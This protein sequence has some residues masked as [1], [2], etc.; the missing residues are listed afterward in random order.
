VSRAD[1]SSLGVQLLVHAAGGMA[2]LLVPAVLSVYKPSGLT[3][4]G[5]R[6]QQG[7]GAGS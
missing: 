1:L 6:R 2:V 3:P 4:H 5:F 7:L